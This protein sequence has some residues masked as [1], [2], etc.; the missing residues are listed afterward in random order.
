MLINY[1][2]RDVDIDEWSE[3]LDDLI[4]KLLNQ[5]L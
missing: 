1:L 5:P 2:R 4:L 3:V